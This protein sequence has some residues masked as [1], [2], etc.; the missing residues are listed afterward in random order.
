MSSLMPF[1]LFFSISLVCAVFHGIERSEGKGMI[2]GV[3]FVFICGMVTLAASYFV[4]FEVCGLDFAMW[5]SREISLSSGAD[6]GRLVTMFILLMVALWGY[7]AWD[8]VAMMTGK[9]MKGRVARVH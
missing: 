8:F 9:V 6:V 2:N 3:S 5:I 7:M 4:L 1:W